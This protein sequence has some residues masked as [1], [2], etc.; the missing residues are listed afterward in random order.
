MIGWMVFQY[1]LGF[2]WGYLI[3]KY[4][5]ERKI[6]NKWARSLGVIK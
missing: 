6:L 3:G 4:D 2:F 5:G 1:L